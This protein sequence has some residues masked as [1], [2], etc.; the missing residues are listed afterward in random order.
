[1][2]NQPPSFLQ[3][4][5]GLSTLARATLLAVTLGASAALQ[6]APANFETRSLTT[7]ATTDNTIWHSVTF[8]RTFATTPVVIMGPSTAANAEPCVVRV[9]NVTTTGF[10]YQLDEWDYINTAGH[11][12]ETVHFIALTEGTHVFGTQRWQVGR[13]STLN[14]TASTVT[15]N[16]FAAAPVVLAQVE[17]TAN[18]A[19]TATPSD[20]VKAVKARISNVGSANFQIR[21]QTQEQDAA[22]LNNETAG[23]IAVSA[24][25][26]FL[27][28]KVLDAVLPA[29]GV[30][31][32]AATV[33]FPA[34]RTA[35][36]FIAQT[37]S[38]NEVDPGELK[39][40]A[41]STT[42]VSL[43][44]QEEASLD[45][46]TTHA[47]ES[48]G[49]VVL[50]D[51]NGEV[52]AKIEVGDLDVTQSNSANWTKVNLASTYTTPVVV[53]GPLSYTNGTQHTI[54][55]RNVLGNDTANAGK[56]SFEF[57][58]DRWDHFTTQSHNYLEHIS[59][60]VAESGTHA[61]GG[62]V[63]QA[64]V[65]SGV[66][67]SAGSSRHCGSSKCRAGSCEQCAGHQLRCG[68]G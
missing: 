25:R 46:E 28:G 59:Y 37:Q 66:T 55:V 35:P 32:T 10:Q 18:N 29:T 30:T 67:E 63:W 27:D 15:L 39:Y 56:G 34:A 3:A 17:S 65:R 14:R 21:A 49:Y 12:A 6:A 33:T 47:S 19:A 42:S 45:T 61:V 54:R 2:E 11:P 9:R 60:L 24:G 20:G 68:A 16:G 44:Y 5:H 7:P 53:M 31:S 52:A 4:A 43:R 57:Q 48:L 62:V 38:L 50:G 1:M 36:I 41:L 58:V 64:G 26:G 51:M 40:S 23:Y 13:I 22:T 8:T